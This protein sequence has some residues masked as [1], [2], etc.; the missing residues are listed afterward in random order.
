M[1][2]EMP[3]IL[4]VNIFGHENNCRKDN[5]ELLQPIRFIYDKE[6]REV[7]LKQFAV[8]NVR[9]PYLMEAPEDFSNP[10]YCWC[11]LL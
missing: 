10:L 6:P 5:R 8:F 1:A 2:S 3:Y 11:R 9:P 7:A 4:S